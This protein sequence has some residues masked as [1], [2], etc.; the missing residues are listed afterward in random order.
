V[1]TNNDL[2][3]VQG[4]IAPG[5]EAVRDNMTETVAGDPNFSAQFCAY[6][7]GALAVD[8]WG[9]TEIE[10]D[11]I[12]G[13]F[14]ATKGVS[15]VCIA[16][17][18][19][20]GV[21]DLDAPMSR[22]WPEFAQAGK[23]DVTVRLALSHQAGLVGVEPQVT[24]EQ[25]IDHDHMAAR[26]AAQAPHWRPGAAQGYHALTIG[27]MMDELVRRIDGRSIAEFFREEIGVP[28]DI[29]FFIAT[30][31]DQE[32]RVRDVLPPEPTPEQLELMQQQ[33]PMAQVDSLAGMAFNAAVSDPFNPPL[34]NVR[35]V[36]AAGVASAG[37]T[38]SARGLA[39][40][41]ASC[42]SQ[43]DGEPRLLSADTVAAVTQLQTVGE[44][45]VLGLTT[46]YGI[47]F[48]KSDA[49]LAYGSHQ[50]FG[51]DGAGGAIGIADP[52]HGLAYGYVPRRMSIP[53]G[54][55][56]RGLSLASTVRR[57]RAE[58]SS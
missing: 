21:L 25:L 51:H 5:F 19:E 17:L 48:Q 34:S 10:R 14:S 31:A 24:V 8:I 26:L 42:I 15:G 11:S 32:P 23:A 56:P 40:L 2:E 44:D 28:R 13:V 29:D 39:R 49:R 58:L 9:G 43:V 54:A 33:N 18:V 22:Y 50:A 38:G 41:F 37:G 27:T 45:M 46:R 16:V 57:C 52:W 6:V 30:P 3:L 20:R 35:A 7:D 1:T 12:Q 47:V 36:R 53:G 4:F 55:D